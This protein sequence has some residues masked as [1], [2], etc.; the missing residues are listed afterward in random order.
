MKLAGYSETAWDWE[1]LFLI[2]DGIAVLSF[3]YGI[4]SQRAA[5]LQPFVVLTVTVFNIYFIKLLDCNIFIFNPISDL[6]WFGYL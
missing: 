3:C 2:V 6:C 5:F 1:L 4:S